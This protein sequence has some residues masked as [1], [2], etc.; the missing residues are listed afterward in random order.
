MFTPLLKCAQL[1]PL[2]RIGFSATEYTVSE[3]DG[4]VSVTVELLAGEPSSPVFLSLVTVDGTATGVCV[5]VCVC[6]F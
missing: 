4:S 3:S 5:C 6:H 2:Y 1:E